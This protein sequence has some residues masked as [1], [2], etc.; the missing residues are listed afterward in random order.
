MVQG[1]GGTGSSG[2]LQNISAY[3][4]YYPM[5][6]QYL[7]NNSSETQLDFESWLVMKGYIK[8]F[9]QQVENY[10][11]TGDGTRDDNSKNTI[12]GNKHLSNATGALY[13]SQ[14]EDTYYEFDWASGTYRTLTGNK[15]VAQA[16]GL[17]EGQ[18]IDRISFGYMEANIIDYTFG[19]T[20]LEDGQDSSVR[21]V[22]GNYGN[23][24]YTNQEFDIH[25]IL[26]SLLMDPN[27]PQYKIAKGIFDDLA[28]NTKQWLPDSAMEELNAVATEYGT[29]SAEYKAKLQEVLLKNLDQAQEWVD[30]HT[31]VKNTG[32][33]SLGDEEDT[34]TGGATEGDGSKNEP[35]TG[36]VPDYSIDKALSDAG[37]SSQYGSNSWEGSTEWDTG[38]GGSKSGAKEKARQEAREYANSIVDNMI[39]SI[40]TQIG[41]GMTPEIEAYLYKAKT[42]ALETNGVCDFVSRTS[43]LDIDY[44]ATV[45]VKTLVDSFNSNFN[46]LCVNKGKT[47]AEVAAE[48][49]AAEEKAAQQKS[50]YQSLY[51]MDM[52]STAK[53]AGINPDKDVQVVN[54]NSAAEI[55]AKA[56]SDIIIPLMNKIKSQLSNKGISASDLETLLKN[57]SNSAL[58][59][60]TD[61][62]STN[63]NYLY[64]IDTDKLISKF[65]QE[66]KKAVKA[67]GYDF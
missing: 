51:N 18:N 57:A 3:Q 2:S 22:Y 63:N 44:R 29:N 37:I 16:M 48:K 66:V 14:D 10:I 33:G 31:H 39:N 49:K 13:Q 47:E 34:T 21:N 50:A 36:T 1:V 38:N 65:E 46:A 20:A 25:Y 6:E 11:E 56:E 60:C 19:K 61:W 5:Y 58:T 41:E 28:N 59:D 42:A 15:E 17:P 45:K 62:A 23:V 64:S 35:T 53:D 32:L 24:S 4:V 27:D 8:N 54:V 52:K 43:F 7:Q 12:D 55:K 9:N 67:K 40:K 30:D 26:N